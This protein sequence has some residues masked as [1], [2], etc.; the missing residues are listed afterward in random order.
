MRVEKVD[1]RVLRFTDLPQTKHNS[2]PSLEVGVRYTIDSNEGPGLLDKALALDDAVIPG[3]LEAVNNAHGENAFTL[4]VNLGND[5]MRTPE[6]VG[7]LLEDIARWYKNGGTPT[8]AVYDR[9]G[10]TVGSVHY[11]CDEE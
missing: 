7:R 2:L 3:I 5:T 1:S 10:N 11:H 6:D 4:R 9:Y 8:G